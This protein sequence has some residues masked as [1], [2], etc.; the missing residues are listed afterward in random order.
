MLFTKKLKK[1]ENSSKF[2]E[3]QDSRNSFLAHIF[4]SSDAQD[5]WQ[6]GY[7]EKDK[8][9]ITTFVMNSEIEHSISEQIF[10]KPEAVIMELDRDKVKMDPDKALKIMDKL[11]DEKYKQVQSM[12]WFMI[13][14]KLEFGQVYNITYITSTFNT[15]NAKINSENGEVIREKLDSLIGDSSII[16]G[17]RRR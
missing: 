17:K 5:V 16:K 4:I 3:W 8:D 9:E 10:K 11:R 2:K 15:L 14:Q 7:Y 6:F 12:K 1:L 13:L